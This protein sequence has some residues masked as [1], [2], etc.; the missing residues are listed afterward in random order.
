MNE[1]F[2]FRGKWED[3]GKWVYG[4]LV[5]FGEGKSFIFTS[6]G[7]YHVYDEPV[8]Q[9]TGLRDKYGTLIFESDVLQMPDNRGK[10]VIEWITRGFE[11]RRLVK[12]DFPFMWGMNAPHKLEIIG[13]IHD[14]AAPP[15]EEVSG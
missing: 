11:L 15:P 14:A 4:S 8:E 9:C 12:N 10:A 6:E 1:R 2:L 7:C 13:N 3:N 5:I